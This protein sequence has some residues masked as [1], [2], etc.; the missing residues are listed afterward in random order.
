MQDICW[1]YL[2]QPKRISLLGCTW[3]A[4]G[5]A[6]ADTFNSL[7]RG[8]GVLGV[9]LCRLS[10]RLPKPRDTRLVECGRMFTEVSAQ[11][12]HYRAG[13]KGLERTITF[14]GIP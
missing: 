14:V 12:E 3:A 10:G 1:F 9:Q 13:V 5:G 4:L 8:A 6:I 2:R 7:I 11:C